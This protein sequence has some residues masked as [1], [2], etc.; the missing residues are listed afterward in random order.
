MKQ[1]KNSGYILLTKEELEREK[2]TAFASGYAKAKRES[3]KTEKVETKPKKNR[4]KVKPSAE[5]E[6]VELRLAVVE[7]AKETS[8]ETAEDA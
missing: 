7:S 8:E 6:P 2:Q 4:A 3:E 5:E 1:A